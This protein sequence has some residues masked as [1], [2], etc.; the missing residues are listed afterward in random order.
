MVV[1]WKATDTTK[2]NIIPKAVHI[3]HI[4]VRAPRIVLG[5]DS[6][7]Y[8]GVVDDLAP[9]AKPSAKRAINRLTQLEV[10]SDVR[11]LET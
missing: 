4:I 3:C 5:A 9:T 8:T 1:F 6:A 10:V 11:G 2:P 7:A